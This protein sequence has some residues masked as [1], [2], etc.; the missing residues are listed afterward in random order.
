MPGRGKAGKGQKTI[1]EDLKEIRPAAAQDAKSV[2]K[3]DEG[4]Q[5]N[6]T[7]LLRAV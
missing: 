2:V 7:G 3:K 4:G 6:S 1:F 5:V